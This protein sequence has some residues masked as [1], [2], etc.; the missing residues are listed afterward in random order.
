MNCH[1]V[2][3]GSRATSGP[4]RRLPDQRSIETFE[5][6]HHAGDGVS[7]ADQCRS[8]ARRT[9]GADLR[10]KPSRH[11]ARYSDSAFG[12]QINP[13]GGSAGGFS[14]E[15]F[16]PTSVAMQGRPDA[17]ASRSALDMPSEREGSTKTS[18]VVRKLLAS[19]IRPTNRIRA[20]APARLSKR[21][22]PRHVDQ[23]SDVEFNPMSRIESQEPI[24]EQV[25][26]LNRLDGAERP[27]SDRF[28]PISTLGQTIRW[29]ERH[30]V[31]DDLEQA[32]RR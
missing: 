28:I 32:G 26:A 11:M 21:F 5:L 31:W 13:A 22:G 25:C 20:S 23:A 2:T 14:S 1:S 17:M 9:A 19:D 30:A 7:P 16:D 18:K 15:R 24:H 10:S 27:E 12:S 8:L 6:V 29:I 4:H 3:H